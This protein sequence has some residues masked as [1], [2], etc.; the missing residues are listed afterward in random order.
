M[1]GRERERR[2]KGSSDGRSKIYAIGDFS[3]INRGNLENGWS[4][5]NGVREIKWGR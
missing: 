4:S 5:K 1:R 2:G 3:E